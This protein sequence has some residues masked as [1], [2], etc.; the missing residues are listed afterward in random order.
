MEQKTRKKKPQVEQEL[1][2]EKENVVEIPEKVESVEQ[3]TT[4]ETI[5]EEIIKVEE[6]PKK[7]PK[8]IFGVIK[9]CKRLRVRNSPNLKSLVLSH[10]EEGD[11]FEIDSDNSTDTFYFIKTKKVQ[12]FCLKKFVEIV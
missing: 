4:A 3:E 6:K 2:V 10:L 12:G 1:I 8:K 7:K 5:Q 11:S 9:D